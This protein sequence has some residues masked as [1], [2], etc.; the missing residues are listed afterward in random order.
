MKWL[1]YARVLLMVMTVSV[2]GAEDARRVV[3][4]G[5]ELAES[6]V[7]VLVDGKISVSEKELLKLAIKRATYEVEALIEKIPTEG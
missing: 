1:E 4:L 5:L 3:D 2:T 7:K 6:T